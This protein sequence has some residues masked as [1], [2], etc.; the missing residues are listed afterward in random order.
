[1]TQ[2]EAVWHLDAALGEGP[3]WLPEE[4]ALWFVDIK[5]GHL[6]RFHPQTGS[7]ETFEVGGN[8]SFVVPTDD[9]GL[10]IGSRDKVLRA[11]GGR[12]GP[13]VATLDQPADNRTNDAAVDSLGRL[14]I[15][16]MHDPEEAE[17]GTLWCLDGATL[18]HAGTSAVVTN[19]PAITADAR[20]LYHVDSG[21]RTISR[22]PVDAE[23]RLGEPEPFVTLGQDEGYPDGIVLDSEDC[24]WV[25]LWDGWGVRRY[26]PDGTMLLHV[27][28]PCARVTKLALGGPDLRT[29]YVTTARVGLDDAAL[30]EQPL[31]G[32]LFTFR[33]DVPGRPQPAMRT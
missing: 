31:A 8:P 16:T 3:V 17:T 12:L 1:M 6:H 9:G 23:G 27:P 22:Y 15:A 28:L 2:P 10:V 25:A 18:R 32:S 5:R 26:A 14:W 11:D 29:A 30:A 4:Q 21:A 20:T 7:A 19:G 13:I 24:V 33:V